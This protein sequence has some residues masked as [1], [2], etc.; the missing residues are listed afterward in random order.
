MKYN[1]PHRT[2]I[3]ML[4]I[5]LAVTSCTFLIHNDSW[6]TIVASIG[7]G[8][9]ASVGVAWMLDIRSSKIRAI[10]DNR[11]NEII[12]NQFVG[13]YRRLMWVTA[14]ECYGFYEENENR[15]FQSWLSLLSTMPPKCPKEGQTSMKTRC[16]RISGSII[17][18]Q[19]QIEIFQSQSA[20]LVFSDFPQVEK[21]LQ[22]FSLIWTH[23]W[24][25]LKTLERENY[26]AFCDTTYILFTDFLNAFPMYRDCFPVEYSPNSFEP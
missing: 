13:I 22:E 18:L 14:N 8:G 19:R 21:S 16:T 23:C 26:S 4:V 10:E 20:T 12:M 25:T 2:Y 9:I 3:L 17:A 7:A 1:P 5:S 11:K 24:G 6:K 15:S